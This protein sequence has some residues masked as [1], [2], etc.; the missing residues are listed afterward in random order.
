MN[1]KIDPQ[2]VSTEEEKKRLTKLW[3]NSEGSNLCV[4]GFQKKI[5]SKW[6]RKNIWKIMSSLPKFSEGHKF[7]D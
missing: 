4:I 3:N 7:T 1:L 2:K 6:G 5:E